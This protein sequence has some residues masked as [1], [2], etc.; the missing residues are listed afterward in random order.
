M[1]STKWE[2]KLERDI[3][4]ILQ[5]LSGHEIWLTKIEK[6]TR[7]TNGKVA[8][9]INKIALLKRAQ[10]ECPARLNYTSKKEYLSLF[11][12]AILAISASVLTVLISKFIGG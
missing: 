4:S 1:T 2:N 3:G 5:H 7:E 8:D 10:E 11:R 12:G 9:N 6:N